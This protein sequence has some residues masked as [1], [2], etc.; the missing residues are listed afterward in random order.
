M[1]GEGI[2]HWV[3]ILDML[4]GIDIVTRKSNKNAFSANYLGQSHFGCERP[5]LEGIRSF[6]VYKGDLE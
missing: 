2:G 1:G 4:R 6:R 5:R 3:Y